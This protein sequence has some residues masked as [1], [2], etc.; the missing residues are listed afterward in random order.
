MA[1][2]HF[3]SFLTQIKQTN[4]VESPGG[5]LGNYDLNIFYEKFK[6]KLEDNVEI[7]GNIMD[8]IKR[9]CSLTN[10]MNSLQQ[11]HKFF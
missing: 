3:P 5:D 11:F 7:K 2:F 9:K 4:L 6:E 8:F 1:R 10:F